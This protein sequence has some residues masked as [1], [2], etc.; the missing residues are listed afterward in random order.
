MLE[1]I[2]IKLNFDTNKKESFA[3]TGRQIQIPLFMN[4]R[5]G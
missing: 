2:N 1:E 5:T 4:K 3:L